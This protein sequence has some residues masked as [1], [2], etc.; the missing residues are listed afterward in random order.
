M[1]SATV[2]RVK[3]T[4]NLLREVFSIKMGICLV[5]GF[6]S[7]MPLFVILT[8]LGA[9]LRDLGV[10]L[11]EIGLFSLC[12]FPYTWKFVWAPL[13][14]R[15][16]LF[17]LGRRR[18][19]LILSQLLVFASIL[20]LGA[21]NPLKYLYIIAIVCLIL[22]FASATQDIVIDAYR[23]EI[24]DDNEL[25]LGNSLFISSYRVA[26]LVPG[27]ISLILADFMGWTEVFVVTSIFML[28]CL[29]VTIF[30]KEPKVC[31]TPR[32]LRAA[33]TEPFLE[34][35]QRKGLKHLLLIV[36]FVFFYKLGD[37]MATALAT[38]FYIDLGYSLKTIGIV[39]KNAGLWSM[40]IGGILGGMIMLKTGIN[41]ALWIFGFGQLI[42]I[43]GFVLLAYVKN[44]TGHTPSII[45]FVLV[46]VAEFLGAGLGTAAFVSFIASTTNKAYT[47]TQ[48]ALLTSLSAVPRT[49][50]NATT[51]FIVES[52]GWQNFFVFC[53][54]LAV[55]GMLLLLKVAPFRENKES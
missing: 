10:N 33:I 4:K 3:H 14:D 13:V 55:P 38:P 19:W 12:M 42:T 20:I 1:E 54:I 53:T 15:Y 6:A 46:I 37:S 24:L 5:L 41:K 34:F 47:A 7:G 36:A 39:A 44:S 50:C 30:L 48:F 35:V 51:G 49:F 32:T 52:L 11:K 26:G 31:N 40:I 17:K 45:L 43:L 9:F 2:S 16:N 22:S 29:L 21:F 27:G 18:S 8:L 28:P 23:R 25:G